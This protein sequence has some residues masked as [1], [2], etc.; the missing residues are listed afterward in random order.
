MELV[1]RMS[2]RQNYYNLPP[3][4]LITNGHSTSNETIVGSTP[5][6]QNSSSAS[7]HGLNTSF[8]TTTAMFNKTH[9]IDS[10]KENLFLNSQD[11]A[12]LCPILLYKLTAPT[13]NERVGCIENGLLSINGVGDFD[14]DHDHGHDFEGSDE[15]RTLGKVFTMCSLLFN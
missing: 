11:L 8:T 6:A 5:P 9:S 13:S 2:D 10:I 14:S 12:L 4:K 3:T 15:D 1:S 7:A